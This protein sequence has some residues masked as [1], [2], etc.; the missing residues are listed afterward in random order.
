[1]FKEQA[2]YEG[3]N[4]RN[5][6]VQFNRVNHQN[7]SQLFGLLDSEEI[8]LHYHDDDEFEYES[9]EWLIF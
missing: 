7:S 1:M 5:F 4:H 6:Q 8:I 2:M 9:D 3:S